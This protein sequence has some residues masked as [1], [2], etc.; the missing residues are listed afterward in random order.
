MSG[1][2]LV[3]TSAEDSKFCKFRTRD[4]RAVLR[5]GVGA[6]VVNW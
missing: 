2:V 3:D 5:V 4:A 1:T 6:V